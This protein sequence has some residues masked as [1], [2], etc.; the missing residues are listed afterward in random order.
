MSLAVLRF[1]SSQK[2]F[3]LKTHFKTFTGENYDFSRFF[4]LRDILTRHS[5]VAFFNDFSIT[6]NS[7]STL[8][9]NQRLIRSDSAIDWMKTLL[10]VA[11]QVAAIHWTEDSLSAFFFSIS[12]QLK[13]IQCWQTKWGLIY[14]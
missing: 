8:R 1:A 12:S 11:C 7:F 13:K 4:L 14:L 9:Y 3:S 6:G 5:G 10:S 2:L